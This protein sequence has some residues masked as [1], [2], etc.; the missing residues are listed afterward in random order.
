MKL[1]GGATR[2]A[3]SWEFFSLT[4]IWGFYTNFIPLTVSSFHQ[5][6]SELC[7]RYPAFFHVFNLLLFLELEYA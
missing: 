7:I 1:V 5:S 2:G 4:A 3:L 6:K